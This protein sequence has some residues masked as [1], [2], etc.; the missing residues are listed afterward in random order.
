MRTQELLDQWLGISTV[1]V[2]ERD[3]MNSINIDYYEVIPN[4]AEFVPTCLARRVAK[5]NS[6]SKIL[7]S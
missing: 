5:L 2:V 6:H 7:Q 3:A 4:R 1:T